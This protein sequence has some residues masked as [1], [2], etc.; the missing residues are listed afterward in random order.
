[1]VIKTRFTNMNYLLF[2]LFVFSKI[3]VYAQSSYDWNEH[4]NAMDLIDWERAF[5]GV[6][7]LVFIFWIINLLSKR[8]L[9]KANTKDEYKQP[10]KTYKVIGLLPHTSEEMSVPCTPEEIF[11]WGESKGFLKEYQSRIANPS[12][13]SARTLRLD[14]GRIKLYFKCKEFHNS[15]KKGTV[16]EYDNGLSRLKEWKD[17]V[18]ILIKWAQV[19][20]VISITKFIGHP[21]SDKALVKFQDGSTQEIPTISLKKRVYF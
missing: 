20:E 1:M 15:L 4:N 17:G 14:I 6:F 18:P 21:L 3:S 12:T 19:G 10:K 5:F 2:L 8:G 7:I 13:G 9:L 16:V 11:E